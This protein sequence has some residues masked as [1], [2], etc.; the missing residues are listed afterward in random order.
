MSVA[1]VAAAHSTAPRAPLPQLAVTGGGGAL[2]AEAGA[3]EL[4]GFDA[5]A[6]LEFLLAARTSPPK[7]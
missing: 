1:H 5:D 3:R 7:K 4:D 6:L 2:L